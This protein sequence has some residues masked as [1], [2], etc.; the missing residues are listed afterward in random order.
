MVETYLMTIALLFSGMSGM[1]VET[2]EKRYLDVKLPGIDQSG[3]TLSINTKLEPMENLKISPKGEYAFSHVSA[4]YAMR[5]DQDFLGLKFQIFA[6]DAATIEKLAHPANRFLLRLWDFNVTRM[7]LDHRR[8]IPFIDVYLAAEGQAGGEHLLG[9]DPGERDS[10]NTPRRANM[11]YIYKVSTFRDPLEQCRELAHEY[12]HAS[13]HAI[14]GFTGPEHWANGDVGERIYLSWI[15]QELKAGTLKSEDVMGV[16]QDALDGYLKTKVH[17]LIKRIGQNG[18]N[19]TLLAQTDPKAF[20]EYVA[21]TIYCEAVLPRVA[22]ARSIALQGGTKAT[23]YFKAVSDAI[24]EREEW[25]PRI[26]EYLKGSPI[27]L[28]LGKG[29]VRGGKVLEKKGDWAKIQPSSQTVIIT[30][31]PIDNNKAKLK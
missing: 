7:R 9:E 11:I 3:S 4:G 20:E 6:Q 27:W 30:N 25:Q 18:P 31:P 1:E 22:F 17:P 15:A 28:P 29:S 2:A 19:T 13:I 12:G 24:A 5:K 26:P 10:N 14:G 21:I 16:S 8:D 23:D